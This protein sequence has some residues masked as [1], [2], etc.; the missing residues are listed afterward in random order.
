M[1]VLYLLP[2]RILTVLLTIYEYEEEY[3]I[4][5]LCKD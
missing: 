4:R 5:K 1:S 2:V 3:L